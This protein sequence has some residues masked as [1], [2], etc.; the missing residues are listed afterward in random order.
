[1][2]VRKNYFD[3]FTLIL[4]LIVSIAGADDHLADKY[5]CSTPD[6]WL[7]IAGKVGAINNFGS[8]NST[9]SVTGL[10][11]EAISS[12]PG[13]KWPGGIV[14]YRLHSSLTTADI[15]EV[16]AA[17]DEYHSK[18][19]IRFRP[20]RVSDPP[21]YTSIEL[22]N[23]ICGVGHVCKVGGSQF[24][25][26]GKIC[27]NKATMVHELGHNLCLGHEHQRSD[28]DRHISYDKCNWGEYPPPKLPYDV[29]GMYDYTSQMHYTCNWCM[30]GWPRE[31][32]VRRC[33]QQIS[34]GLSV[35][36]AD[37][38]NE[39]YD[40]KGTHNFPKLICMP[41]FFIFDL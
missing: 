26:F 6:Q 38:I 22:D 5:T 4:S 24:A 39:L 20:W 41:P 10:A 32:N 13:T 1:M 31:K 36:D 18:T 2:N 9:E 33:G 11:G 7:A 3:V 28:R 34:D 12:L 30:G 19:C 17:F 29:K 40:C 37:Y 14:K 15:N 35:L 21:D 16:K 25:K 8:I 23:S 27:R